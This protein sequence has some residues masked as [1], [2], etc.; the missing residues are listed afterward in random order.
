MILVK[1]KMRLVTYG[2]GRKFDLSKFNCIQNNPGFPVKPSGGLWASPVESSW[3]WRHWCESE[4][5]GV[6]RL[7]ESFEFDYEG[8]FVVIDSLPDL[9]SLPV[10]EFILFGLYPDFEAIERHGADAIHLTEKGQDET[11]F[12]NPNLYGWDCESV[13]VMNPSLVRQVLRI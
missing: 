1:K 12:G 9:E 5:W 2:C 11:Q 4:E 7:G 6:D 10:N 8:S 13:L 3:G